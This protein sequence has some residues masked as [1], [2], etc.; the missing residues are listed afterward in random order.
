MHYFLEHTFI[1]QKCIFLVFLIISKVVKYFANVVAHSN[2]QCPV[3]TENVHQVILL[4]KK[5]PIFAN[6]H[7]F[8]QI[9]SLEPK[10]FPKMYNILYFTMLP[11]IN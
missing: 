4:S 7:I 3:L 2:C 11:E 9:L 5:L 8:L 10:S 6:M 1:K